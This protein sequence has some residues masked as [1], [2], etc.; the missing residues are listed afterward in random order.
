MLSRRPFL[1]RL[2]IHLGQF[3]QRAPSQTQPPLTEPLAGFV[4][5]N[6]ARGV[7]WTNDFRLGMECN[8]AR[9]QKTLSGLQF[10]CRRLRGYTPAGRRAQHSSSIW[11]VCSLGRRVLELTKLDDL[12]HLQGCLLGF[13]QFH[14]SSGPG[15]VTLRR[16][17]LPFAITRQSCPCWTA[18]RKLE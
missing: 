9:C 18:R 4:T 2:N 14:W 8:P 15:A 3:Q 1:D 12:Q 17:P 13:A 6:E 11:T 5:N 16:Q 7:S 10:R